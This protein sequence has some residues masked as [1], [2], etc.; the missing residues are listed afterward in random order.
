MPIS[1]TLANKI[2][3]A[4]LCLIP[5]FGI[6]AWTYGTS[7]ARGRPAECV[8]VIAALMFITIAAMDVLD[9]FIARRF[10]QR[11]R[12]GAIL[13]PIADKGLVLTAI[14]VLTLSNRSE[15]FPIWF[16]IAV[17]GRDAILV[18]GF[19]ALSKTIGRVEIRPSKIGKTATLL[20]IAVILWL[21]LGLRGIGKIYLTTVATLFTI[22]SGL[23]YVADGIRQARE[24]A[25]LQR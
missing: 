4:R 11:S 9:G 21:L 2:T 16:P 7:V 3:I 14:V 15:D 19:L 25:R 23:G 10:N 24:A 5:V 22:A 18:A 1:M 12:L 13:D 20:Q 8:R 17:I 6:F